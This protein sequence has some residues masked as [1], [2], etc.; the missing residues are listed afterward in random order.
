MYCGDYVWLCVFENECVVVMD[1]WGGR[2]LND[3]AP[4]TLEGG[5]GG[6]GAEVR[7]S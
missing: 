3:V 5:F 6:W 1:R 4:Y 2:D 7:L